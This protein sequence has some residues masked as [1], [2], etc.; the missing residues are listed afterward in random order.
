MLT[1]EGS[2]PT[3]KK[4]T[5]PNIVN[6]KYG[7]GREAELN[8]CCDFSIHHRTEQQQTH[9]ENTES[10]KSLT[11]DKKRENYH[12]NGGHS[13]LS[14]SYPVLNI[15]KAWLLPKLTIIE[16]QQTKHP[17]TFEIFMKKTWHVVYSLIKFYTLHK[18][19]IG[20]KG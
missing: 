17:R 7:L 9:H 5:S 11:Q 2:T 18:E 19:Y 4:K 10:I 14:R 20:N 12:Q 15:N 8:N 13:Y 3:Q 1:S 16:L 6:I